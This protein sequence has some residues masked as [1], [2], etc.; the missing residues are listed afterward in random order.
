VE[1]L[2]TQRGIVLG[3]LADLESNKDDFHLANL[4]ELL[5]E[6]KTSPEYVQSE[7]LLGL[8]DKAINATNNEMER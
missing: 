7:K 6:M 8:C 3:A 4:Y 5:V 2:G 1:N